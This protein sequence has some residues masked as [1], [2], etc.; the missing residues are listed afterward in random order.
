MNKFYEYYEMLFMDARDVA[1]LKD[2]DT[3]NSNLIDISETGTIR[4]RLPDDTTEM[5][6]NYERAAKLITK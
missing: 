4:S 2:I 6:K 5:K 1:F 3:N